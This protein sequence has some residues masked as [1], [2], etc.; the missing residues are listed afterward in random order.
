MSVHSC[1]AWKAF[2]CLPLPVKIVLY[3][4]SSY[5]CRYIQRLFLCESCCWRANHR[6]SAL[7]K[8]GP[9]G[10]LYD[11][12]HSFYTCACVQVCLK[13]QVRKLWYSPKLCSFAGILHIVAQIYGRKRIYPNL[14]L[15]QSRNLVVL[16]GFHYRLPVIFYWHDQWRGGWKPNII[17]TPTVWCRVEKCNRA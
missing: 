15:V 4:L 14:N 8:V 3:M 10:S 9:A 5:F 16:L 13:V 12:S 7:W 1:T 2:F 11:I 6:W 17:D